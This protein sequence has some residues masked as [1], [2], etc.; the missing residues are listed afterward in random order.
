MSG[1]IQKLQL[2]SGSRTTQEKISVYLDKLTQAQLM[3]VLMWQIYV[4][5]GGRHQDFEDQLDRLSRLESQADELR[6]DIKSLLYERTLIPDLRGDVM[7][8]IEELDKV[9][10]LQE[11]IGF[12]LQIE[13]PIMLPEFTDELNALLARVSEAIDYMVLC[14]RGFLSDMER[15]SEYAQKVIVLETEADRACTR[16]KLSIFDSPDL[17]LERKVQLRYFID[18]VDELANMAEDIV[19]HVSISTLKRLV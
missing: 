8:L 16:L 15:V 7:T 5:K 12:H 2:L 9:I 18:R 3:F 13:Q 17:P 1:L 6:R 4:E 10:G 11:A 14:V 19:D